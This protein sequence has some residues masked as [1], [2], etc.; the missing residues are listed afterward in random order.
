MNI[1]RAP[2]EFMQCV[3][4]HLFDSLTCRSQKAGPHLLKITV[5]TLRY[6][7]VWIQEKGCLGAVA[8]ND[9]PEVGI[10]VGTQGGPDSSTI[11]GDAWAI[12]LKSASRA[13]TP[14]P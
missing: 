2:N 13:P 7:I 9:R 1:G 14:N 5:E 4:P 11:Q 10:Q 12:R 3:L 6:W 8:L